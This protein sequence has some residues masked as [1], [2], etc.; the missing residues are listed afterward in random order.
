MKTRNNFIQLKSSTIYVY[1]VSKQCLLA[2]AL[3][4]LKRSGYDP[5]SASRRHI[6]ASLRYPD[7]DVLPRVRKWLMVRQEAMYI[8]SYTYCI[9]L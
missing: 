7:S 2:S 6:I 9:N 1:I 4:P 3:W 8:I 5:E